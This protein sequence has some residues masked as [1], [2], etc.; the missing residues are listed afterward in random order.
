MRRSAR[1]VLV[2]CACAAAFVAQAGGLTGS[3]VTVKNSD[4]RSRSIWVTIYVPSG[5]WMRSIVTAQCVNP[6]EKRLFTY[7]NQSTTS[8]VRAEVTLNRNCQQ[9]VQCDTT[10]TAEQQDWG[11]EVPHYEFKANDKNCWWDKER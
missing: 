6:G 1:F 8:Y 2:A 5:P 7:S 4:Y 10:V 9:P 3:N 11:A